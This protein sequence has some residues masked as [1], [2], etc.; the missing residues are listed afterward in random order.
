MKILVM[1]T[2]GTISTTENE[3][4]HL[5]ANG[6]TTVSLLSKELYRQGFSDV[7]FDYIHPLD[8]LSEN[9]TVPRL[10]RLI[11]A[12][13][14]T[15]LEGY[16]SVIVAH[17]TDTLAYTSSLLS[18]VLAGAWDKPVFLVSSNYTLTDER[19]NGH[20]NFR[21]AVELTLKGFG[22]GVYVPYQNS[23]NVTYLHHGG[24]LRNCAN[25]SGDFFSHDMVPYAEAK[26]YKIQAEYPILAQLRKLSEC[27]LFIE[28]YVGIDYSVFNISK[29]IRAVLHGSY[30][31]A[32]ACAERA[33]KG[34]AY[35][36]RSL[37]YLIDEC[38]KHNVDIFLSPLPESMS[39]K[40]GIYSTTADLISHGIQP[41]YSL[42]KETAYMKLML[43][44]CLGYE[45]EEI[46]PFINRQ[47]ASEKISW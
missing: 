13:S 9:M 8:I 42:T 38:K 1:M 21:A 29:N 26:P 7:E 14:D 31:S 23:D 27:V 36:K 12:F 24:H 40:S 18:L 25:Y 3:S 35:T 20:A 6:K 30:H 5:F 43:A 34:E 17:G 2:G 44:Y 16:D 28:P 47:I 46:M 10:N 4:G 33:T 39:A 22:A 19:A 41:I 32:T 15:V 37:L 11:D 45:G